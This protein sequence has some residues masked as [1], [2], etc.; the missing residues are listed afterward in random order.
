MM[1]VKTCSVGISAIV[2]VTLLA[3]CSKE[4]PTQQAPSQDK[5]YTQPTAPAGQGAQPVSVP[6]SPPP[7]EVAL[8]E[9][10]EKAAGKKA[11]EKHTLGLTNYGNTAVTVTLNGVWVGQWDTHAS[12]PL[13]SVG[14]GKNELVVELQD[15]PKGTVTVEV[16]AERGGQNV[17][18]LRLNFQGKKPGKYTYNFV[19]K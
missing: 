10:A 9:S 16:N 12:V 5:P 19:A 6:A 8:S 2:F 4:T 18:L 17:N 3:S 14:Q 15:E 7:S 11:T 13:D 1:R